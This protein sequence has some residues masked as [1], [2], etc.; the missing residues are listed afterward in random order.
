MSLDVISNGHRVIT[1]ASSLA[2]LH[3]AL[4]AD[5]SL[6][7]ARQRDM[8]SALSSLGRALG[9]PLEA[10]QANPAQ[11]R[12]ALADLTPAMVGMKPGRWRNVQS[13]LSVALAHVGVVAVQGRLRGKP[14]PAWQTTL[15]LLGTG[16]GRHYHLWRFARYCTEVG[17]QPAS[18]D[19][20]VIARY[21][22]D[23]TERSLVSHPKRA[24]REVARAW[25]E[26]L[27]AHP[28]WPQQTL[29]IPDNRNVYAPDWS[30]YPAALV[31]QSEAW[32]ARLADRRLFNG[33]PGKA[34]KSSSVESHRRHLR[35]YLGALAQSGVKPE[36]LTDLAAA[37][38]PDRAAVAMNYFWEKAGEHSTV[39]TY[40]LIQLVL[41]IARHAVKLPKEQIV[42]LERMVPDLKPVGGRMTE[43]NVGRLRQLDDPHK[44]QT[45]LRL[46]ATLLASAKRLGPPT[47]RTAQEVQ[48]AAMVELLLHVPMRLGNL[49]GLRLGVN[50]LR[51][52][53]G[54]VR[55]TVP[56]EAVKNGTPIDVPLPASASRLLITYIDTY[57]SLLAPPQSDRLFPGRTAGR[58]K[59]GEAT[60]S[61]IRKALAKH[62]GIDFRPHG[63]RHLA[64]YLILK[65]DPTAHGLVQ[66]LLGHT[67]LHA[68]MTFYSGLETGA[69]H[70]HLDALIARQRAAAEPSV[71]RRAVR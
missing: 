41:A 25:N 47:V 8:L 35:A 2:E 3:T 6:P 22:G 56:G 13:L 51:D 12:E 29:T 50:V 21:Q 68:T 20:A 5:R 48:T 65:E 1:T 45:L 38:H 10:I 33:R 67:S 31:E 46:P 7:A 71:G 32:F 60:R 57:R 54:I 11:L 69:A 24:A 23:L 44:L 52:R 30:A 58:P 19:D 15:S 34:L 26:A 18:V 36:E 16:V 61:Q 4:S 37:V 17:I 66:R 28:A 27:A 9:R 14:S 62:V 40:K 43:R 53:R 70:E 49:N 42:E 55:V 64:A 59:T 39:Y 63:F